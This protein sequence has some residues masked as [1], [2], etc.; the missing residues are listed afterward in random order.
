[1]KEELAI[2]DK[3]LLTFKEASRYFGIGENKLRKMADD[4]KN[5]S[6]ILYNGKRCLIKRAQLEKFLENVETI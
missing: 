1:M 2:P 4:Y 6:W 5:P 3:Y